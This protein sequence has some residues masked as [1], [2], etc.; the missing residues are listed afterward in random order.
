MKILLL[1]LLALSLMSCSTT[2]QKLTPTKA[3]PDLISHFDQA[4]NLL[5]TKDSKFALDK[6]ALIAEKYPE[7]EIADD[8]LFILA[9]Y[10]NKNSQP[11]KSCNAYNQIVKS[12]Y[13]SPRET[14]ARISGGNCFLSL[15]NYEESLIISHNGLEESGLSDDDVE[16]LSLIKVAAC[17]NLQKKLCHIKTL[18]ALSDRLNSPNKKALYKQETLSL[19]KNLDEA[20]LHTLAKDK[21]ASFIRPLALNDYGK[22]LH[23]QQRFA[24]AKK[25][26]DKLKEIS[27]GSESTITSKQYTGVIQSLENADNRKIGVVLPQSGKL[28]NLGQRALNGIQLAVETHNSK[29]S[30]QT[31][32]SIEVIDS[33]SSEQDLA[34]A[35]SNLITEKQVGTIIGG[36]LSKTSQIIAE[37]SNEL[38]FPFVTLS[39]KSGLTD[40][41]NQIYQ[42][43]IT[44]KLQIEK[45]ADIAVNQLGYKKFAVLYPEDSYGQELSQLFWDSVKEKGGEVITAQTYLP[46]ETDFRNPIKKL[47]GTFYL[48]DRRSEYNRLLSEWK[49]ENPSGRN[50]PPENLLPPI[51][52]FEAVFIP[53]TPK[54]LGQLAP[55]LAYYDVKNVVLLGTNL[56]NRKELVQRASRHVEGAVFLDVFT[57]HDQNFSST[58]FYNSYVNRYQSVPKLFEVQ[59]YNAAQFIINALDQ[60]NSK[61]EEFNRFL[62]STKEFEGA[63]AKIGVSDQRS[64]IYP[65]IPLTVRSREI[66]PL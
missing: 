40:I 12:K 23:S 17:K 66:V 37:K 21:N 36:I 45:L 46:G 63:P 49:K 61:N 20:N 3:T 50:K 64:F 47:I 25:Y 33:Q 48:E 19:Y 31:P 39:Q 13:F 8:S 51:V 14:E 44:N 41:G 52:E 42:N 62:L 6:L 4:K 1:T 7:S 59:G 32:I 2:N 16:K 34:S 38:H 57:D 18:V 54:T 24:E 26:F 10:Y 60:N 5:K 30:N 56:W 28:K 35:V 27:P 22:I 55:M 15:K 53:D 58:D 9:E 11:I 43:A 29:N 65:L